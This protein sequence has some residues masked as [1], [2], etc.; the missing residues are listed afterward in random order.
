MKRLL[1]SV[2]T[3]SLILSQAATVASALTLESIGASTV[4]GQSIS[5]WTYQGSNPIFRGTAAPSATV[6]I[7]IAGTT[8]TAT[9]DASGNWSYTPTNLASSGDYVVTITEGSETETFTLTMTTTSQSTTTTTSTSTSS[10]SVVL[11]DEL[12]QTGTAEETALLIGGGLGSML[13][14]V[15]FYWKV[16]PKLLLEEESAVETIED[17][18]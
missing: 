1:F 10:G 14:G 17:R 16:V 6:T 15:L 3:A 7:D 8:A 11:P 5:S 13:I 2:L 4:G 12:P 18:R 9:A